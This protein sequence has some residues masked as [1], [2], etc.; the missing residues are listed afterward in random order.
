V[1]FI[2]LLVS[3]SLA[4]TGDNHTAMHKMQEL[5]TRNKV[6]ILNAKYHILFI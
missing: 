6:N 1:W 4:T 5:N 2:C 3:F